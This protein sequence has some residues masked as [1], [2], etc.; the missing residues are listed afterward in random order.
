MPVFVYHRL[1]LYDFLNVLVSSLHKVIHLWLVKGR[2]MT[3]DL[4]LFTEFGDHRIFEIHTIVS[5]DS[6]WHTVSTNQIMSDKLRHNVLG[7]CGKRG[8]FNPLREV[9][10]GH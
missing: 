2:I 9:I 7:Y 10:N 4:E 3:L 8:C 6:L 1:L 5:D